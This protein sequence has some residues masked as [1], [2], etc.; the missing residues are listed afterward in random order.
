LKIII[1]YHQIKLKII[2]KYNKMY[3]NLLLLSHS[4]PLKHRINNISTSGEFLRREIND[5]G[6]FLR[7]GMEK[8]KRYIFYC[9]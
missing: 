8:I 4:Q 7:R 2:I 1:K 3:H 5:S 6:V 9:D